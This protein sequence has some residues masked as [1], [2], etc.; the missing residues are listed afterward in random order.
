MRAVALRHAAGGALGLAPLPGDLARVE[1]ALRA[2]VDHDDRFL[3]E[4]APHLI[5]AGGKRI[6]P[7]AHALRGA[8]RRRRRRPGPAT[9]R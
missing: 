1:A 6:R 2:S 3:A 5:A 7:D 8:T 9:T 4:V